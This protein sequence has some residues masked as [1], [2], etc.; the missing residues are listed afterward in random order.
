MCIRDSIEAGT[1]EE[2]HMVARTD[3]VET[4]G[5][6][7]LEVRAGTPG[8]RTEQLEGREHPDGEDRHGRGR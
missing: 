4:G 5:V 8:V 6:D 1:D 7:L 3:V 2:A